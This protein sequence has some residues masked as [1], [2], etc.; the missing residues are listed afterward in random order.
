[1]KVPQSDIIIGISACVEGQQVRFDRGHKK[2]DFCVN[3]LGKHVKYRG[4]CP[5]VA[6]G[7]PIPRPT[8]RQI[9]KGD[10]IIVS[11][12]DGEGDVTEQ[13]TAY[14]KKIAASV[15]DLSGFIFCQKSPSCGMERVKVYYEHGQSSEPTGIGLFAK[16]IMAANPL[17]PCEENGRLNDAGL[18]ENFVIRVFTYRHWQDL[19]ASGLT[20]HKLITFHSEHKYLL[21]S[22]HLPS[23]KAL[24]QLLARADLSIDEMA[25]QYISGL[26][27]GLKH[28]ANR[29][30]HSNT[31]QHLQ[32]YFKKNIDKAQKQELAEHIEGFRQ[33]LVPLLVPL[34][35]I[36]HYL[37]QYPKAYLAA[38]VYLSPYPTDLKLR[39]GY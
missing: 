7:M 2:S 1:M 23:Y 37:K 11:R 29:K 27:G 38:Q 32:G 6:I 26:M 9:K 24:G 35:L 18:R 22:H 33:G 19:V 20:K 36:N 3:E 15:S 21:M 13:L 17:L 12:P 5:E 10:L 28:L 39:Y 14:G 25:E 34:T 16:E 31:L 30:S 8:V 4:F